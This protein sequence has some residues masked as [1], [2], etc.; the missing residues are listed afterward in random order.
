MQNFETCVGKRSEKLRTKTN[1]PSN[2][3]KKS[4]IQKIGRQIFEKWEISE[5][6][7]TFFLKKIENYEKRSDKFMEKQKKTKYMLTNFRKNR[8]FRKMC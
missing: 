1:V 2:F 3:P 4:K 5:N 6:V 7:M 8:K